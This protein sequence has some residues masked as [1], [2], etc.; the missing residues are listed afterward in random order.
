[1]FLLNESIV[2][3]PIIN[4]R[5]ILIQDHFIVPNFF[6]QCCQ[7]RKAIR[8]IV[9]LITTYMSVNVRLPSW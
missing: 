6:Y 9:R 5:I 3:Y 1:M 8:E 2:R 4:I 7:R